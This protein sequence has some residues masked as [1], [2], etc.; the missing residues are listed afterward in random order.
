MHFRSAFSREDRL[1]LLISAIFCTIAIPALSQSVI[2]YDYD[3]QG[4]LESATHDAGPDTGYEYDLA[5]N[6]KTF[7][8]SGV[9]GGAAAAASEAGTQSTDPAQNNAVHR[10]PLG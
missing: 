8:I 2:T 6:R 10:A 9:S 7:A 4:Q 5:G 1:R 3:L